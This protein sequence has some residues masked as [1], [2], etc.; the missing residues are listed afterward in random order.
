MCNPLW[1]AVWEARKSLNFSIFLPR[2]SSSSSVWVRAYES[3]G[4]SRLKMCNVW[5]EFLVSTYSID[6]SEVEL[7]GGFSHFFF[8]FFSAERSHH[9]ATTLLFSHY[10]L[11][12]CWE[13]LIGIFLSSKLLSHLVQKRKR[14][15]ESFFLSFIFVLCVVP[16]SST[17]SRRAESVNSNYLRKER[18]KSISKKHTEQHCFVCAG[19]KSFAPPFFLPFLCCGV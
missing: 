1:V 3:V 7:G 9:T 6:M 11:F 18:K 16:L 4:K 12:E 14:E 19:A 5:Y 13:Y 8:F 2:A 10:F 17:P 15:R